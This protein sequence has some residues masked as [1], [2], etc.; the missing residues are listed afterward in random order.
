MDENWLRKTLREFYCNG[1]WDGFATGVAPFVTIGL[2]LLI[3]LV[4]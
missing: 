4:R 2:G 1:W 3:V